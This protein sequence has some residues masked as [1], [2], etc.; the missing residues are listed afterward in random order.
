MNNYDPTVKNGT[1]TI[2]AVQTENNKGQSS[3][4]SYLTSTGDVAIMSIY[5]VATI[6]V[7]AACALVFTKR[8]KRKNGEK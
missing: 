1:L 5:C 4:A 8:R 7:V 3:L 6:L 2:Q